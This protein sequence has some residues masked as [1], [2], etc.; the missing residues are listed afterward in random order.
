[1]K[2]FF[3]YFPEISSDDIVD[4][5]IQLNRNFSAFHVGQHSTRPGTTSAHPRIKYAGDWVKLPC[6][7][8]LMEAAVTSGILAANEILEA[9]QVQNHPV[10]SVPLKGILA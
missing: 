2:E 1:M 3:H 9:E 8:M 4:T 7:A 10:Y 5:Y 6:P